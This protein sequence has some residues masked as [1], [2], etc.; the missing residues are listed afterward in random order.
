MKHAIGHVFYLLNRKK[1]DVR[2]EEIIN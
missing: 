1:R 2:R